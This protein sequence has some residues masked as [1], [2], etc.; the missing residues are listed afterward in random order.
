MPCA[1][2][3]PLYGIISIVEHSVQT[4]YVDSTH[5]YTVVLTYISV[6]LAIHY[7]NI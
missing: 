4:H 6:V 3:T 2:N 1:R 5:V 7:N